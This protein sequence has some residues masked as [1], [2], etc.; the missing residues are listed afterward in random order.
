MMREHRMQTLREERLKKLLRAGRPEPPHSFT[1]RIYRTMDGLP[2]RKSKP[3]LRFSPVSAMAVVAFAAF[4]VLIVHFAGQ[5]Q[6]PGGGNL[7]AGGEETETASATATFEPTPDATPMPTPEPTSAPVESG[8]SITAAPSQEATAM[9]TPCPTPEPHNQAHIGSSA[10]INGITETLHDASITGSNLV[11]KIEFGP[12]ADP[13][14]LLM[15]GSAVVNGVARHD[16]E[17]AHDFERPDDSK[18]G[19][20][21]AQIVLPLAGIDES[22]ILEVDLFN[23]IKD[24]ASGEV[25]AQFAFNDFNIER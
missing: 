1:N 7:V 19:Y 21:A 4:C 3:A 25:L 15:R 5:G 20:W 11:M 9:P 24:T 13:A 14:G 17:I 2:E 18:E 22:V 23:E 12:M 6:A 8:V 16:F 10:T